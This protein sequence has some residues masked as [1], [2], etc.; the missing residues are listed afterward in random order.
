MRESHFNT[1]HIGYLFLRQTTTTTHEA[2]ASAATVHPAVT[3]AVMTARV[4]AHPE[5]LPYGPLDDHHRRRCAGRLGPED[6]RLDNDMDTISLDPVLRPVPS[7]LVRLS[8]DTRYSASPTPRHGLLCL[9]TTF[10]HASSVTLGVQK[11]SSHHQWRIHASAFTN[12]WTSVTLSLQGCQ[13]T[14]W[15]PIISS[16][17]GV[18]MKLLARPRH[19][20]SSTRTTSTR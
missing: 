1:C 4:Q 13:I 10:P 11:A 12:Y 20:W 9:L 15:I 6:P 18:H 2:A 8:H 3:T 5:S 16:A 19:C 7:I 14:E 17:V